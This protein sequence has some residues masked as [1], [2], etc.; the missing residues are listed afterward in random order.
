MST[1]LEADFEALYG[2]RPEG[3][4]VAPGRVNLIGEHTDYNDGFM[5]PMAL[6]LGVRA[7]VARRADESLRIASRQEQGL[8]EIQSDQLTASAVRGWAAYVAGVVWALRD[9]GH[10]VGGHDIVCDGDLP[11]EAGL[12]SSAAIECVTALA[13]AELQD[14]SLDRTALA[15][16]SQRAENEFVGVPSGIMDQFAALLCTAD[17][18]ML[19]DARSL[20]REQ[21]PLPM[22]RQALTLLVV[23]TGAP[24]RLADGEYA[25]R[26]RSCEEAARAL[27]LRALRDVSITAL[28][29]AL[30]A[31]PTD[32]MRRRVRHVVTENGRVLDAAALLRGGE[33]D[34]LGPLL[35]ASHTSLRDDYEV[36]SREL[37]VAVDAAV[38]AGALGAR[39]TGA[40]FGG[41][42]IALVETHSADRVAAAVQQAFAGQGLAAPR[43]FTA[44]AGP[45]A[46]RLA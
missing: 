46:R 17:H 33:I 19:L 26:R 10:V 27:G 18:A 35:S 22:E 38:E 15:L 24:R 37:N 42:A 8:V 21:L 32:E 5:L 9:A 43:S 2:R 36:S 12:S 39:L 29:D 40:G 41:S 45:G 6:H 4:W 16:L 13:V 3:V 25:A 14:L 44:A 28:A 7:A 20:E 11:A 1:D 34:R 30:S 31:L 23:D